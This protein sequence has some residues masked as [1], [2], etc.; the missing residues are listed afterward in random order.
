MERR[1]HY[2]GDMHVRY[3]WVAGALVAA[4]VGCSKRDRAPLVGHAEASSGK[5]AE[6]AAARALAGS[7]DEE[8]GNNKPGKGGG[9]GANRWR[10]TG[11]YVDG[12]PVGV[13]A[14]GELPIGLA[15]TWVAE[16]HSIE[17]DVG[18]K[19]PRTR[20]T[21]A[22]RYRVVDYLK[23]VGVD[24]GRIKQIQIMGPKT[25]QVIIAS[26]KELRSEKGRELMFRFGSS[27]GGKAIPVVPDQFGNGVM[28]DKMS[29]M[30]VYIDKKPPV[31]VA[32]EGLQLDG[33][34]VDG[35][36]YFGAPMRGGVRVYVDDRLS[37]AIKPELLQEAP[38]TVGPDGA[39][40]WKL[41]AVLKQNGVDLSKVVEAWAIADERRKQKFTRAELDALAF[42][43]NPE[44]KNQIL[45]GDGKL[46]V[47]AL[48]LHSHALA[49]GEL[50]QIR[51]DESAD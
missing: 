44:Q 11:V 40:R 22:R 6:A 47:D 7:A 39:R 9:G 35:V 18:Y 49:P 1:L 23:A 30:M 13:L 16:E 51:P 2:A 15:P 24:V 36:P 38:S 46:H 12:R 42:T 10:D 21:Y 43:M 8:Y 37:L 17:F 27:V 4:L 33:K 32:E 14:F 19:G 20:K 28:P 50:P 5:Q 31:L 48:A 45:V 34:T 41:T 26:G 29:A 3:A 25:T